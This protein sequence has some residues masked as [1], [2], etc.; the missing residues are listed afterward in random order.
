MRSIYRS[1]R[2]RR[3]IEGWCL[4]RLD[5]WPVEHERREITA[6]GLSTHLVLAGSGDQTAVFVPGTNFNAASCLPFATALYER[7]RLVMADVP[8]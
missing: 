8:G 4:D 3:T 1:V 6:G 5:A 7:F 2:G